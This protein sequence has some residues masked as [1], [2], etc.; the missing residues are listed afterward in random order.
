MEIA[1]DGGPLDLAD[2]AACVFGD[3]SADVLLAYGDAFGRTNAGIA[4]ERG[5]TE[6]TAKGHVSAVLDELGAERVRAGE[7]IGLRASR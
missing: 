2:V 6:G 3:D 5:M 7:R 1:M 4:A